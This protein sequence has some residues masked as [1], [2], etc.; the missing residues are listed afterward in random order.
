[1]TQSK[2]SPTVLKFVFPTLVPGAASPAQLH[3]FVQLHRGRGLAADEI[4]WFLTPSGVLKHVEG[5]ERRNI[6]SLYPPKPRR[7]VDL[8]PPEILAEVVKLDCIDGCDA[9]LLAAAA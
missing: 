9:T 4:C 2:K 6:S 7:L 1:M 5:A 3:L 8:T